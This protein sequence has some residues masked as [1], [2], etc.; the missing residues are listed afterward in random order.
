[1]SVFYPLF[2]PPFF[3][4]GAAE[5][6]EGWDDFLS[7]C[8]SERKREGNTKRPRGLPAREDGSMF[9]FSFP[10][11]FR[12]L[13]FIPLHSFVLSVQFSFVFHS[14]M[15]AERMS[16]RCVVFFICLLLCFS[17]LFLRSI[18]LSFLPRTCLYSQSRTR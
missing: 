7:V 17:F 6:S 4:F 16:N 5:C 15:K 2:F 18:F 1:M 8:C 9:V 3:F 10:C 13:L 11:T 14:N 12:A